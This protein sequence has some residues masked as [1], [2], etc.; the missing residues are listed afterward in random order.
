MMKKCHEECAWTNSHIVCLLKSTVLFNQKRSKCRYLKDKLTSSWWFYF[1][2]AISMSM[3]FLISVI[4]FSWH[5]FQLFEID[6]I[7]TC[8]DHEVSVFDNHFI[9]VLIIKFPLLKMNRGQ[10]SRK[11]IT[12]L[13]LIEQSVCWPTSVYTKHLNFYK[14]H[15]F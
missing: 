12:T 1:C 11:R 4:L 3:A 8:S 14:Y 7:V 6:W 15:I 10:K 2:S 9:I 5:I 13:Y